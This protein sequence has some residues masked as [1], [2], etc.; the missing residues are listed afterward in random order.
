MACNRFSSAVA[1][2]AAA[3]VA[4]TVPANTSA[5][6]N[7]PAHLA[8]LDKV[9]AHAISGIGR[10]GDVEKFLASLR[11][12]IFISTG[13]EKFGVVVC[14][15]TGGQGYSINANAVAFQTVR[16]HHDRFGIWL[17]QPGS[18]TFTNHREHAQHNWTFIGYQ[19]FDPTTRTVQF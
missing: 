15:M 2:I 14:K 17:I 3:V 11:E 13:N 9:L 12:E 7:D 19:R 8:D 1:A 5:A 18:G 10:C 16:Y 4:A 6:D